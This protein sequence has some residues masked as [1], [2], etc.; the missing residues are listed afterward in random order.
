[1]RIL[2]Y[3]FLFAVGEDTRPASPVWRDDM[4]LDYEKQSSQEFFRASLSQ[5]LTF[6]GEDYDYIM[7]QPFDTTFVLLL[8]HRN[9]EGVWNDIHRSQFHFTDC[10]INADDGTLSVKPVTLD[11]YNDIL[12]GLENEYNLIELCPE[13]I[14]VNMHKRGMVQIYALGEDVLTCFCTGMSTWEQSVTAPNE[15]DADEVLRRDMHFARTQDLRDVTVTTNV[16]GYVLAPYYD[17]FPTGGTTDFDKTLTNATPYRLRITYDYTDTPGLGYDYTFTCDLLPAVIEQPLFQYSDQGQGTLD[18]SSMEFDMEDDR[19]R[20]AHVVIGTRN[21]YARIVCDVDELEH[22]HV[23]YPLTDSDFC[24]DNRNYRRVAPITL[25]NADIVMTGLSS[26][27][28]TEYGRKADGTYYASPFD[29]ALP[30]GKTLWNNSS[31]WINPFDLSAYIMLTSLKDITLKTAYPLH[32]VISVLLAKVAPGITFGNTAAYS[33]F[34]YGAGNPVRGAAFSLFLTPKSNILA[35][36]DSQPA[37]KAPVTLAQV[38]NMLRTAFGC[39]WY[40]S[41]DKKLHVE[42]VSWFRNGGSYTGEPEVAVDLTAA[43]CVKAGRTWGYG[44]S[45]YS[46]EKQ[47]MTQRYEYKWMDDVTQS[48]EGRPVDVLGKFVEQG[49]RDEVTVAA[50]TSD[51]DYMMLAPENISRDGFALLSATYNEGTGYTVPFD[52]FGRQNGKLAME[53]L[54]PSYLTYDMPAWDIRVNDAETLAKG[55]QKKKQQKVSVPVGDAVPDLM[56]LVRTP[57]GDGQ[58]SALSLSLA[59]RNANITLVYDT[60]EQPSQPVAVGE[61]A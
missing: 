1:M 52:A 53:N 61:D 59:S 50:F 42:H 43:I 40:I 29:G 31:L 4:A 5:T 39:Y 35:G 18:T 51:L 3:R 47:D 24:Y 48:F 55:I 38:L 13:I 8:Q 54:I 46:Y 34:L 32:S 22:G 30:V 16:E 11:Q 60:T 17:I 27:E 28:P 7:A 14:P 57:L 12:A 21:L 19:G 25:D 15:E 33:G 9:A 58:I 23:T 44:T 10:T 56:K 2:G 20:K 36:E 49:K 41:D 45:L 37:M 6:T 26:V